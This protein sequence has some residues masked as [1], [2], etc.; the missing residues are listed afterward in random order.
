MAAT[1]GMTAAA[2]APDNT[3]VAV[4][5]VPARL[6]APVFALAVDPAQSQTVLIGTSTGSIFRSVD[7]GAYWREV[8]A[9]LGRGVL[10]IAFNPLRPGTVLAGG[11][12]AGIWRSTDSGATWTHLSSAPETSARAFAFGRTMSVAG[13]DRGILINTTGDNWVPAGLAQV[14]VAAVAMAAVN[15]PTRIFAGGDAT[16]GDETLPLYQSTDGGK[17]WPIVKGPLSS[18]TM[19]AALAAGPLP[20]RS[21]TRPLLLGTNVGAFLTTDNGASW[22]ALAG[23][24]ATD[25]NAVAFVRDHPERFYLASDGGDTDNGGVWV[26]SDGGRSFRTLN[27]PLPAVTAIAVTYED[28]PTVYAAAFRASDHAAMIWSIKDAGGPAVPPAGG[29]PAPAAAESHASAPSS[30]IGNPLRALAV[31]PE[32]PYL[33]VG[34]ISLWVLFLALTSYVRRGRA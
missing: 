12:A 14:G 10:S 13:T 9:G 15:D 29:V 8:A 31:G 6:D 11:R 19:V 32:A 18:S 22:S 21:D 5:P 33:A 25:F 2:T 24:P 1:G 30:P 20:P 17:T 16:S 27:P 7:G 28:T 26:T 23:L 4:A 3:W 34:L